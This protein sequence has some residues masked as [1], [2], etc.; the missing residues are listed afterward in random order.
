MRMIDLCKQ[1]G[2]HIA[3]F[4]YYSPVDVL[5][6]DHPALDYAISCQFTKD[7]HVALKRHC[8]SVGIEYMV[9]VFSVK[10]IEWASGLCKRMKVASRM[11]RNLEFLAYI[12]RT[13]LPVIMS[14]Q[15]E[16][17]MRK[18]YQDR[19]Y[20][21]HCVREYPASAVA[22]LAPQ[23]SYKYGLSSH[24]PD[25]KVTVEAF[26]HGARIFENHVKESNED[27]GCDMSSSITIESF[28]KMVR[29]INDLSKTLAR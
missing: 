29:A 24:C 13:K 1:A 17:P 22:T 27:E 12:D 23:F 18:Y 5:G 26:Q 8:D 9:S 21:M 7:E 11:N 2:A 3:K 25:Y 6:A 19:F 28:G 15:P 20:F 4:Q 14:I 10:D 16:T